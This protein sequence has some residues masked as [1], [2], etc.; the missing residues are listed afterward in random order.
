MCNRENG[1]KKTQ[2]NKYTHTHR[3]R[4]VGAVDFFSSFI[5]VLFVIA[6]FVVHAMKAMMDMYTMGTDAWSAKH[7]EILLENNFIQCRIDQKV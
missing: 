1:G 3:H 2:R 5:S 4:R 6:I 7:V